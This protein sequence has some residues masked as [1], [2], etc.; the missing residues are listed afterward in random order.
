MLMVSSMA[1]DPVGMMGVRL[2]KAHIIMIPKSMEVA[3]NQ[4]FTKLGV[5]QLQLRIH[6]WCCR[7]PC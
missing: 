3:L 2:V 7:N 1:D 6:H 4:V 5:R